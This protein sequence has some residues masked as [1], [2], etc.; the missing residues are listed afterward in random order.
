MCSPSCREQSTLYR[1][2]DLSLGEIAGQNASLEVHYRTTYSKSLTYPAEQ[3]LEAAEAR[4]EV[5]ICGHSL[6]HVRAIMRN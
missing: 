5:M 3:G 4:A 6:R 1:L 2:L